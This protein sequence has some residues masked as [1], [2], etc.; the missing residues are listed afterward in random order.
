MTERRN[1]GPHPGLA[2]A[3]NILDRAEKGRSE[4][5]RSSRGLQNALGLTIANKLL[6]LADGAIDWGFFAAAHEPGS[7]APERTYPN[8]ND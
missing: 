4:A 1:F 7:G 2:M 6:A 3:G 5:A 8:F